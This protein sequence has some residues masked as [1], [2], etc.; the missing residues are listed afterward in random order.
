MEVLEKWGVLPCKSPISLRLNGLKY[1]HLTFIMKTEIHNTTTL[2]SSLPKPGN[3]DLTG[4]IQAAKAAKLDAIIVLDDDP[5][6]TQTVHHVPV[7]TEWSEPTLLK[8]FQKGTPLFY[9]LTNSRS[10]SA[11]E[12]E[13][14]AYE[15]GQNIKVAATLTNTR[16]WVISRSDSTLRGHYPGEVETLELG[17]GLQK[18]IH[19]IIPAFFEGGRYTIDNIHYVQ[20]NGQLIPAAQTPY[21][22]DKVF[23]Y[24]FSNLTDWIAEKTKGAVP[25]SEVIAIS[26]TAL[27]SDTLENLVAKLNQIEE[28][29]TCIVNAA[30][31]ADL[32]FFALALLKSNIQPILRTAASFVAAIGGIKDKALL[33]GT[34]VVTPGENGGLIVVG[35]YVPA[36]SQQLNHLLTNKPH[37]ERLEIDVRQILQLEQSDRPWQAFVHQINKTI[38]AGKTIV[39]YTSRSL[40]SANTTKENQHIGSQLSHFVVN[41]IANLT[42]RPTY[43][44]TKGGIT[45]SDVAT[46]GLGVTRAMVQGQI[47]KGVPVWKLGTE[48]KFPGIAQIIFPGNVGTENSLTEVVDKLGLVG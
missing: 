37:L 22:R 46:M 21:A 43:I 26:I 20:Q 33:K 9:I 31:Y 23:G 42:V 19:F 35:S 8:E 10:L 25:A 36:T 34:E 1:R 16:Y 27:R 12:A 29:T 28:G 13:G 17:L 45:S 14:L 7:L 39:V 47:I 4:A 5:T 40:V 41:I 24:H 15:I 11:G 44:L 6:G 48:T 18:S 2:L 3:S 30:D 32:R 38:Q